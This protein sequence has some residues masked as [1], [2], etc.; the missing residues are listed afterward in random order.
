MGPKSFYC[1]VKGASTLAV[2]HHSLFRQE[3][4]DLCQD[5]LDRVRRPLEDALYKSGLKLNDI[6]SVEIVGG[7]TRI[8]AVKEIISSVFQRELSTTL[9]TDEAVARG[10]A[11]QVING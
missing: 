2:V 4:Q 8:P 10:C 3:F 11:L 1:K 5:L 7:S 9:N 6:Y